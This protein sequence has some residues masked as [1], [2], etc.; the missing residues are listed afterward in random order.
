MDLMTKAL[1]G[2]ILPGALALIFASLALWRAKR[3]QACR[4]LAAWA[5]P[6]AASAGLVISFSAQFAGNTGRWRWIIATTL[7][8]LLLWPLTLVPWPRQRSRVALF[9]AGAATLLALAGGGL[10]WPSFYAEEAM[11]LRGVPFV[12]AAAMGALLYPVAVRDANPAMGIAIA[13][14]G[15]LLMPVILFSK[16]AT[17]A[18]LFITTATA[19]GVASSFALM[20]RGERYAEWRQGISAG[21]LGVALAFPMFAVLAWGNKYDIAKPDLFAWALALPCLAVALVWMAR[22]PLLA[23][24]PVLAGIVVIACAALV[25]GAGFALAYNQADT[26]AYDPGL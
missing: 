19:A 14:A 7:A 8:L 17:F 21:A 13:L 4:R 11:W 3:G 20:V 18:E 15:A 12:A 9:A 5:V 6:L 26:S 1:W 16:N 24:R 23:R 22:I 2:G 25:A 10:M